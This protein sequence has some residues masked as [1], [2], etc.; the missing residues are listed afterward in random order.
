MHEFARGV[1]KDDAKAVSFYRRACDLN[2]AAGCYNL[3]IM[4]ERGTGVLADREKAAE[5][6]QV[7]C[8]AGAKLA[9]DK[10][11]ELSASVPAFLVEGGLLQPAGS[12]EGEGG[13]GLGQ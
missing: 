5:L 7:A 3:A 8:K 11:K 9:C 12:G 10:A 4:L 13:A 6:Y 1:A 2:W